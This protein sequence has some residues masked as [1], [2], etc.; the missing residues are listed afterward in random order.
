MNGQVVCGSEDTITV[1]WLRRPRDNRT[2][3]QDCMKNKV[4]MERDMGILH[5]NMWIPLFLVIY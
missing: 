4:K 2:T 5:D 3:L 1:V